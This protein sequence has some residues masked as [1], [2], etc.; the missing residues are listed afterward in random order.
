MFLLL[1]KRRK[2]DAKLG[3]C[4]GC[5]P[6]ASVARRQRSPDLPP[7]QLPNLAQQVAAATALG[8]RFENLARMLLHELENNTRHLRGL[9]RVESR[10]LLQHLDELTDDLLLHRSL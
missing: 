6:P 1:K 2:R 10:P 4:F 7:Q 5:S 3:G 8:H 9:L